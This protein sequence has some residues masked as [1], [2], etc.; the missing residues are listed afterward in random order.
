[1]LSLP[2]SAS[3]P[4]IVAATYAVVVFTVVVQGLTLEH[5]L[6]RAVPPR[7]EGRRAE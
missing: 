3:R 6:R 2:P 1:V 5:V 4:L 7:A